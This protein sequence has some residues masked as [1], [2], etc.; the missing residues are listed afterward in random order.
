MTLLAAAGSASTHALMDL[1]AEILCVRVRTAGERRLAWCR[2]GCAGQRVGAR[3]E[4]LDAQAVRRLGHQLLVEVGAF[5]GFVDQM[6]PLF[7]R[8]GRKAGGKVDRV[9][10]LVHVSVVSGSAPQSSNL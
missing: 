2:A 4:R 8:G 10:R 1:P 7:Q 6:A 3:V 5:E 9:G